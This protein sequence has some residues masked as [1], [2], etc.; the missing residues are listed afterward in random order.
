MHHRRQ[1]LQARPKLLDQNKE[2]RERFSFG[3]SRGVSSLLRLTCPSLKTARKREQRGKMKQKKNA[4]QTKGK[5]KE[6]EN[7]KQRGK[8]K[9]KENVR[10]MK[11][12]DITHNGVAGF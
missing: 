9:E 5:M 10:K 11:P 2:S 6:K 4:K 8:M 7:V 3:E 1:H 12:Q